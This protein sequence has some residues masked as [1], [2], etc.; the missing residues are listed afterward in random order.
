MLESKG[1]AENSCTWKRQM[2][3]SK[4]LLIS[5]EAIYKG[6]ALVHLKIKHS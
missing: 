6:K 2:N 1:I 4:D 3:M 5:S